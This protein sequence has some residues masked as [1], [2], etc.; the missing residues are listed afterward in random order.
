MVFFRKEK[1][2]EI[3]LHVIKHTTLS[4]KKNSSYK[5]KMYD[6]SRAFDNFSVS[7]KYIKTTRI[8]KKTP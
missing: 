2:R 8:A 5:N 1:G 3:S 6:N 4:E 7:L